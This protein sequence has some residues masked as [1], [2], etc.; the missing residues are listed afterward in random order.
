MTGRFARFPISAPI[1]PNR[2][3]K[4]Y[5]TL[6]QRNSGNGDFLTREGELF[7]TMDFTGGKMSATLSIPIAADEMLEANGDIKVTLNADQA[8]PDNLHGHWST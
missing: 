5:Y 7:E 8:N 4:V 6:S 1:S 2:S 3:V